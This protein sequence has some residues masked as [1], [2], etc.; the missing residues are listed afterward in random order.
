M[1]I[2]CHMT[3]VHRRDDLRIFRKECGALRSDGYEVHL[4]VADGKGDEVRCGIWIWDVGRARFGRLARSSYSVIKV[5]LRAIGTGADVFHF[6]DPEILT[7]GLVLRLLGRKVIYDVHEDV[8][9]SLV[10]RPWVPRLF[11]P[12]LGFLA[13]GCEVLLGRIFSLNV[14]TTPTIAKRFSPKNT[15]LV[16]NF[17]ILGEL[18]E[19]KG[20]LVSRRAP[21]FV[22]VG[23]VSNDRGALVMVR[24]IN[25]PCLA[26]R[27]RLEVVGE[28]DAELRQTLESADTKELVTFRGRCGREEIARILARA[29]AG[30]VLLQP[31]HAHMN[32]YPVKLFEYL[33]VG[34]PVIASDYPLWRDIMEHGE[35]GF[36]VSDPTSP[37]DVAQTMKVLLESE[38]LD[39]ISE[40]AKRAVAVKY[41]WDSEREVLLAGYERV[42]RKVGAK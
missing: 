17:A 3:T 4:V 16:R 8:P 13:G 22:Y 27:A 40:N 20:E 18:S 34:L 26:G 38:Q 35:L 1:K 36:F 29:K 37:F 6:H 31:V 21:V 2:V 42:I 5:M 15:I 30:L 11:R 33:A 14:V 10:N 12:V 7:A 39:R 41:S 24:A 23:T 9:R 28:V 32:A 25:E 19:Q